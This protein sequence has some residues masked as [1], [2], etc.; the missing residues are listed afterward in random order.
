GSVQGNLL[1]TRELCPLPIDGFAD[2]HG[3]ITGTSCSGKGSPVRSTPC[4]RGLT[5]PRFDKLY[6]TIKNPWMPAQ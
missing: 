4:Q 1:A 6:I 3:L 2:S 5:P